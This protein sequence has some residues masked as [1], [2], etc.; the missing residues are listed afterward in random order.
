MTFRKII[1]CSHLLA[2]VTAG[3]VI[4]SMSFTG[5]VLMYEQQISDYLERSVRWVAPSPDVKRLS[6]DEL[7]AKIRAVSPKAHPA[8]ITVKSDTRASIGVNLG[9]DNTVFINPSN[10][11][12]L[13]GQ[14][15][16]RHFLRDIVDRHRWLGVESE[17]RAAARAPHG[18]SFRLRRPDRRR[19]CFS[20]RLF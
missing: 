8:M 4:F 5:V 16:T 13:G 12:I 2:G 18:R 6:Y 3:L 7:I 19:S 1:F 11:E 17:G 14:S 10:G 9:R 20:W 15:L